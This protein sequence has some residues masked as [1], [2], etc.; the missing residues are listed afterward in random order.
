VTVLVK[1]TAGRVIRDARSRHG[2]SQARLAL[3]A[4]T[5]QSAI[6]RLEND[7]ISPSA[8]TLDSLLRAMG[9]RL[10]LSTEPVGRTYDPL[11]RA[12]TA[13]RLPA[14]RLALAISWNRLAGRLAAAGRRAR[15]ES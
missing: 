13:A 7:E 3:R 9:E 11:H 8:E 15:G 6:S 5:R 10:V 14:E 12:A 1:V 4:G 2:L